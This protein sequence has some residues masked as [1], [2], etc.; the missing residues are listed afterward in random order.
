MRPTGVNADGDVYGIGCASQ[1]YGEEAI[2]AAL[3]GEEAFDSNGDP[4]T[5]AYLPGD[6]WCPNCGHA[7]WM[8]SGIH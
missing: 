2:Q 1:E 7:L 4:I 6:D 3:D 8:C 5:P